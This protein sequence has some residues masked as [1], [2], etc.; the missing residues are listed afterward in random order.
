MRSIR[1]LFHSNG[2][3]GI[4]QC[5]GQFQEWIGDPLRGRCKT[6]L[7]ARRG[8]LRLKQTKRPGGRGWTY[9][10]YAIPK[11]LSVPGIVSR[12]R[13]RRNLVQREAEFLRRFFIKT[14]EEKTYREW[15]SSSGLADCFYETNWSDKDNHHKFALYALACFVDFLRP[16]QIDWRTPNIND[17]QLVA[18]LLQIFADS[19]DPDKQRKLFYG[20]FDLEQNLKSV[21]VESSPGLSRKD[22]EL[23]LECHRLRLQGEKRARWLRT[24]EFRGFGKSPLTKYRENSASMRAQLSTWTRELLGD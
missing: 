12:A 24:R 10:A 21:A 3:P 19:G 13:Q 2:T 16:G 20:I 18:K 22:C 7:D 4:P 9:V 6:P 23:L 8:T 14:I 1:P 5:H 17:M 11:Y 15:L